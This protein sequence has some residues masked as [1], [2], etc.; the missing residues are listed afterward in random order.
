MAQQKFADEEPNAGMVATADIG[1]NSDIHPADKGPIG[2]R[3][4]ALALNRDYGFADIT[5]DSPR[6]RSAR[7]DGDK[8]VVTCDYAAGWYVY[9]DNW[10]ILSGFEIAGEDGKFVPARLV[11]ADGGATA[12]VDWQTKGV[13]NG[14]ELVLRADGVS[15][16][17]KVRYLYEKPWIGNVFAASGLPLG[18]FEASFDEIAK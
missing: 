4:A 14:T 8:A 18:P 5:A 7:A 12:R 11:N 3:L 13:V 9:N 2:R 1:N 16:P 17:K 10:D 6:A 15:A